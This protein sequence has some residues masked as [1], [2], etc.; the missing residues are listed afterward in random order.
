LALPA[1]SSPMSEYTVIGVAQQGSGAGATLVSAV[2]TVLSVPN[3]EPPQMQNLTL[4]FTPSNPAPGDVVLLTVTDESNQPVEG[5]SVTLVKDNMT[6]SSLL[7]D[8]NG[9]ASFAIPQGN[10][11]IR[12]SGGLYH[13]AELN[14]SV[15]DGGIDGGL[16]GDRDGDGVGDTIDA[17]PDDPQE[18]DDTDGDGIGN[19]ADSDDDGDGRS[20]L[21]EL[22]GNPAT[23]PLW[24]DSDND[25]YCDGSSSVA[26]ICTGGDAFPADATEWVDTDDDALGDNRD[27]DDDDD[28]VLDE[29]EVEC[30]SDPLLATSVPSD[31]DSDGICDALD[32][33]DD[34]PTGEDPITC[35]EAVNAQCL[36]CAADMTVEAYCL[37]YPDTTG[38][39]EDDENDATG[40]PG[41]SGAGLSSTVLV[42]A[43]ATGAL[44]LAIFV[45]VL[46]LR[47]R[48]SE[49]TIDKD[50]AVEEAL[51][52][53][54][55][56]SVST[57]PPSKPPRSATGQMYDGYEGLEYPADSGQWYY[58]DP[59]TGEWIEWR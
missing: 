55:A 31:V 47:G 20:D 3:P 8:A 10:I 6:L 27:D 42:A 51:F 59:D 30:G 9:Q 58:R 39:A 11:T 18:W 44:I 54:L 56:A 16:P 2:S 37:E 14:L 46:L 4:V 29:Q 25:G 32:G 50:F 22:T 28:G 48:N 53:E 21:M 35:C 34:R 43:S 26:P 15:E 23:D 45:A 5:L 36:A 13:P 1:L 17:F 57:S 38:C 40:E 7:S 33:T 49:P 41:T 12:V 24:P 52:N 19:N